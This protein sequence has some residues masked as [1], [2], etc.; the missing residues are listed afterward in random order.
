MPPLAYISRLT[1]GASLWNPFFNANDLFITRRLRDFTSDA[2][3]K[4]LID[5]LG[6]ERASTTFAY[7]LNSE[8]KVKVTAVPLHASNQAELAWL[9]LVRGCSVNDAA[10]TAE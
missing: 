4:R 8:N 5:D 1:F 6:A 10:G 2:T 7:R 3:N 9:S